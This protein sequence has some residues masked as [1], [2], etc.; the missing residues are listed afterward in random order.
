MTTE[1]NLEFARHRMEVLKMAR[2]MLNEEYINRRAEDH[3]R[4]LAEA[5]QAWRNKG[6]KLPYPAFAPYPTEEQ[7]LE[8]AESLLKFVVLSNEGQESSNDSN[9]DTT[10]LSGPLFS[11][12]IAGKEFSVTTVENSQLSPMTGD[13]LKTNQIG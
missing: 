10:D 12:N 4:W 5:D 9:D 3:N 13:I 11:S 2:H 7:I 8:K 6:I 1:K